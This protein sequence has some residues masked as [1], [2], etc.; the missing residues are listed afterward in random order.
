MRTD[1][2]GIAAGELWLPPGR[3]LA[4]AA[5]REGRLRAR[6]ARDLGHPEVPDAGDEAAPDMAVHAA[7]GALKQAGADAE[8]LDVVCHAW[9]YYQGHDLWS[10]A[11]YI[12][13]RIGARRAF[14]VGVQQVCNGGPAGVELTAAR[15]LAAGPGGTRWGL[16]TTA[17][18]FTAPGFDRW[19]GDYGVAY[20]DA[21]TAL[22]LRVPADPADAL[23]LRSI[24]T[25]AAPELEG[26][27]RGADPFARAARTHRDR[28]DMRATKRAYLREHGQD[29]FLLANRRS[30]TTIAATALREAGLAPDDPRLRCAV[31]PRFGRKTLDAVW[32]PV[33]AGCLRTELLD[34][35]TTTGHLGAGDA[36]AGVAE[37]AWQGIL[38]PGEAALV[39]SAGAGFTWSCLVVQAR[40]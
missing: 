2:I 10:P 1:A 37:L 11:H 14:P 30:V 26:M 23:L 33:L 17:D 7:L 35:G 5:V 27:H 25:A 24:V 15:L 8:D 21:A 40:S 16:V 3:E 12:A 29:P 34:L 39:F 22:L 6:D 28:V 36:L 18:R 20:G 32:R 13:D 19:A 4:D 38:A 31:L 9:M